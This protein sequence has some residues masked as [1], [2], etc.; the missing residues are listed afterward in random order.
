MENALLIGL[1]RQMALQRE[2]DV[3]AN[4]IA[5]L[6]TTGF[7]A[8]GNVFREYLMPV[9]RSDNFMGAD[10]RMSFVLDRATWHNLGGGTIQQ[11]GNPLDV[12]IDG[13]A[14]LVVQTPQGERYTKNGALQIN[15]QGELVTGDG[16]RILGDNGPIALQQG[17]RNIAISR[18]GTI[19]VKEGNNVA[20]SQRGRLRLV[21][22]AQP[23]RLEKAG[24]SLFA[25]PA[26]LAPQPVPTAG[27]VQG[28]IEK[29]N[30]SAVSEMTRMIEVTRTYTAV[31]GMLQ[32]E[33][34]L[35]RT[36]IERLAEVPV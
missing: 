18:E 29:S 14:F 13:D 25:A 3:V 35:R 19:T 26:G 15:A 31:A 12:A 2:L 23:E 16:Y 30:V 32:S 22:F 9:A 36:A 4:N 17:D 33:H 11:T 28:S 20:E 27:V 5:N 10:R 8:D 34:E 21:G 24:T 7:K 1:S 6:N